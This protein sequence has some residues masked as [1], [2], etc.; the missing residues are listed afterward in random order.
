MNGQ[1]AQS[2]RG[3]WIDEH[4]AD[5][6]APRTCPVLLVLV[7]AAT[8]IEFC[9]VLLIQQALQHQCGQSRTWRYRPELFVMSKLQHGCPAV[10][11]DPKLHSRRLIHDSVNPESDNP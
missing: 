3:Q 4:H 6:L 11:A 5:A 1:E 10:L 7:V 8:K 9:D 2:T